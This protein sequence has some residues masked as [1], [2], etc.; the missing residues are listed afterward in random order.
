[1]C[2]DDAVLRGV[3]ATGGLVVAEDQLNGWRR[4]LTRGIRVIMASGFAADGKYYEK[5]IST[6]YNIIAIVN[7]NTA[8]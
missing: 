2:V 3:L 8:A 1:M 4:K 7:M 6:C 5:N